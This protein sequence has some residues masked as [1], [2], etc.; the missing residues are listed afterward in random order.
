MSFSETIDSEGVCKGLQA[1]QDWS[2]MMA[3]ES[4]RRRARGQLG[5]VR[6]LAP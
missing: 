3:K 5:A 2:A 4:D 1:I 6:G